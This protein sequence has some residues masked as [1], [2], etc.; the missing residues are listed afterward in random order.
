MNREMR[1]LGTQCQLEDQLSLM[2]FVGLALHNAVPDAKTIC[3]IV[4][5][6]PDAGTAERLFARFDAMLQAKDWCLWYIAPVEIVRQ[7]DVR[8]HKRSKVSGPTSV[9]RGLQCLSG[10]SRIQI[11]ANQEGGS[12][13]PV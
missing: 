9:S 8:D 4:N 2:R 11:A 1:V 13:C 3:C 7:A 10:Q 6:W 5:S 12:S